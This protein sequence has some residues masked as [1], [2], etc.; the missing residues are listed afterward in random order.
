MF[1]GYEDIYPYN[2][3]DS[4][5]ARLQRLSNNT[6]VNG[7]WV[8]TY[9]VEESGINATA[10]NSSSGAYGIGQFLPS[11]LTTIGYTTAQLQAMNAV[12]QLDVVEAY[13]KFWNNTWGRTPGSLGQFFLMFLAPSYMYKDNDTVMYAAG[14]TAAK[15]NPNM[16]DDNGDITVGSAKKYIWLGGGGGWKG[17][18]L[19]YWV[20]MAPSAALLIA[21]GVLTFLLD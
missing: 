1:Y 13:I 4:F 16:Q 15:G 12:E 2:D 6:G 14:S 20:L 21:L 9:L 7:N 11:T 5:T 17:V 18:P 8:L 10:V 19:K 3:W